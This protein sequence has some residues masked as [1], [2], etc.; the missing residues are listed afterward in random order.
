[1]LWNSNGTSILQQYCDKYWIKGYDAWVLQEFEK[2][3]SFADS[4][5]WHISFKYQIKFK[6]NSIKY[7]LR[8]H[9]YQV[10][11]KRSFNSEVL[12][13]ETFYH[14]CYRKYLRLKPWVMHQIFWPL[15]F[16]LSL[17]IKPGTEILTKITPT[18]NLVF[19]NQNKIVVTWKIYF[20]LFNAWPSAF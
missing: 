8:E 12:V 5:E 17:D 9:S 11:V 14:Y 3:T 18:R 15:Y 4:Y 19:Q 2:P 20:Q 13:G 6:K 7:H 10:S 1:L 16:Y